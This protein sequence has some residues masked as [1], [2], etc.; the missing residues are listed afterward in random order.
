MLLK[1]L[2]E[3]HI[4]VVCDEEENY[5]VMEAFINCIGKVLQMITKD[6]FV[7][8]AIYDNLDSI[9]MVTDEIVDE[10][11]IVNLDPLIVF[12]RMKMKDPNDPKKT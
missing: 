8:K 6:Q 7:G 10:G 1:V 12:D 5:F 4:Y 11:V 2:N 9:V 3:L